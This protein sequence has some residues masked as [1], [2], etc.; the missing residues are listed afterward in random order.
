MSVI[1]LFE[2]KINGGVKR[3][4]RESINGDVENLKK[5]IYVNITAETEKIE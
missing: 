3:K 2:S 4:R 5:N 1:I